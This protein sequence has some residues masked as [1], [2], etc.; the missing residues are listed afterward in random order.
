[1]RFSI[2]HFYPYVFALLVLAASL[3]G[4]CVTAFAGQVGLAWDA[5]TEPEIVGYRVYYQGVIHDLRSIDVGNVTTYTVTD[6][7]PDTYY[8]C[9]TAYDTPGNETG[10]SNVVST[11]LSPPM[12]GFATRAH[13]RSEGMFPQ[14]E[15]YSRNV[16]QN[17]FASRFHPV[18][19]RL[20]EGDRVLTQPRG[21]R[22]WIHCSA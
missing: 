11:T 21:P 22:K 15:V 4:S 18:A 9:V 6:L 7:D 12:Y 5:K 16:I 10:C 20:R 1:V 2:S 13:R 19:C 8:F 14:P 17:H 3:A